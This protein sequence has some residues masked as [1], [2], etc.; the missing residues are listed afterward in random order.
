ME[1]GSFNGEGS[2]PF[3]PS[4]QGRR[5]LRVLRAAVVTKTDSSRLSPSFGVT[6]TDA[7]HEAI[8]KVKALQHEHGGELRRVVL[9]G[10][11]TGEISK[12]STATLSTVCLTF[13]SSEIL[14]G[15]GPGASPCTF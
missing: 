14:K 6:G 4:S 5:Y 7:L 2:L 12:G 11:K 13:V 8:E 15:H 1:D 3:F 9:T 10:R